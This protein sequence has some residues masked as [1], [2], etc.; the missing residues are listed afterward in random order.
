[1]G[2]HHDEADKLLEDMRVVFDDDERTKMYHQ[3]NQIFYEEQPR[4]LLLENLV[5][6]L[7]NNRFEEIAVLP[8]GLRADEWW[9]KPENVKYD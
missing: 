8:G 6:V 3:F 5:G 7:V 2:W 4:T 9:V 1:M